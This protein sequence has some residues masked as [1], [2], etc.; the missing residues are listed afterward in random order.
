M[1]RAALMA[2]A[3]IT[4]PLP[5]LSQEAPR[6]GDREPSHIEMTDDREQRG[7]ASSRRPQSEFADRIAD[8]IETLQAACAADIEAFCGEVTPGKGRLALCMR[9]HEDRLSRR[10]W[11]T[12]QR[13]G[14]NVERAVERSAE[15]CWNEVRA[16]CGEKDDYRQCVAQ[17]KESLSSACETIV[18]AL[19][20][21]LRQVQDLTAR[22]GMPVYGPDDK[23]VGQVAEV[24]RGPDGK[25]QSIQVDI[26]RLLGLGS[27][28]VAISADKVERV[29]GIKVHL[30]DS[31][32]RSLPEAKKQ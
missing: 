18:T 30:S 4:A 17:K 27:K 16:L 13:V 25:V 3:F 8:A 23:S 11:S 12:L 14:R 20:Q 26:G 2:A 1:K 28:V 31:E 15:N 21:R 24:V 22:V 29:A 19:G 9:A 32:L 7:D 6:S 5:L 10:C